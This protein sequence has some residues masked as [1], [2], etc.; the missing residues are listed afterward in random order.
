MATKKKV[1]DLNSVVEI[2]DSDV[3]HI[4]DA[5]DPSHSP[6]GTSKKATLLQVKQ[7]ISDT[8]VVTG[9]KSFSMDFNASSVVV[10]H[11]LDK[12]PSVTV[13]NSAGDEV[14]GDIVYNSANQLTLTFSGSFVGTV[15]CN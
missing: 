13:I 15:Y 11:N 4:V 6:E 5:S 14:E 10:N 3:L 12:R 2:A 8:L 9:D 7:F 1:T